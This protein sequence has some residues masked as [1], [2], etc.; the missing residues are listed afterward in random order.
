MNILRLNLIRCRKSLYWQ[1]ITVIRNME[2][3]MNNNE[4]G[5]STLEILSILA[6]AV[7]LTFGAFAGYSKAV[8][9]YKAN[10]VVDQITTLSDNIRRHF[11]QETSYEKLNNQM[12][13]EQ[14]TI[15]PQGITYD[16]NTNEI[17]N[18]FKGKIL[19]TSGQ[20]GYGVSGLKNDKKAFLIK[21]TGLPREA[22]I[23]ASTYDWN[24]DISSGIIGIQV[25]GKNSSSELTDIT[26]IDGLEFQEN[27]IAC[28]GKAAVAGLATACVGGITSIPL[29][30]S[31]A[32]IACNCDS[33]DNCAITWKY[34]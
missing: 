14:N 5:R 1:Q 19:V 27:S 31:Q 18:P 3:K 26:G 23:T 6:I 20:I 30:A 25:T 12:L 13:I 15:L 34:Y 33:E 2:K 32:N 8:V 4:T 7:L 29:P 10:K 16:N 11:A 28:T 22:C 24:S 17:Y 21:Y 9:R